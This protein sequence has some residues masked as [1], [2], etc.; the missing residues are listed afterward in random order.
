VLARCETLYG[1]PGFA[2][3]FTADFEAFLRSVDLDD[4]MPGNQP[5]TDPSGAPILTLAETLWFGPAHT[6]PRELPNHPWIH[7]WHRLDEALRAEGI[8]GMGSEVLGD[9]AW[10]TLFST[11]P[12]AENP[13]ITLFIWRSLGFVVD[14]EE[15]D[16]LGAARPAN[17]RGDVG[18]IEAP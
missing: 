15:T 6:W 1:L 13:D 2:A 3:D 9:D 5:Y 16:Q 8:A 17:A 4:T 18:A 14:L 10:Q 11:G 12:L 7:F